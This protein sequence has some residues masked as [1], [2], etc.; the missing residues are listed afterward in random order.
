MACK[1]HIDVEEGRALP[2]MN[3][4]GSAD[5]YVEVRV[6]GAGGGH[7]E[8]KSEKTEI[9]WRTL[10]PVWRA[11]FRFELPFDKKLSDLPI[12]FR[13]FDNDVV[14]RDDEI[15]SVFVELAPLLMAQKRQVSASVE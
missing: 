10:S 12:E 4:L 11:R 13:V 3:K 8:Q 14:S 1:L 15:G 2:V 9:R 7:S 6:P 5:A